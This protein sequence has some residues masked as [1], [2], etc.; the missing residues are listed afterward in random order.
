M[1]K[2][3]TYQLLSN[4]SWGQLPY[5]CWSWL[6]TTLTAQSLL[7]LS[8]S[9]TD[10]GQADETCLEEQTGQFFPEPRTVEGFPG[11][12]APWWKV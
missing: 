6:E 1:S 5:P 3:K 7:F 9:F 4:K 10:S 11:A 2:D 8:R 12:S